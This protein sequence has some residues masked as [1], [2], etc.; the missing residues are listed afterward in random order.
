[1]FFSVYVFV[2]RICVWNAVLSYRCPTGMSLVLLL[3]MRGLGYGFGYSLYSG[4]GTS[5]SQ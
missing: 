3:D 4:C 2:Y 1:M 5:V